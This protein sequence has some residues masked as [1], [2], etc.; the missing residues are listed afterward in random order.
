VWTTWR[1]ENS[2][3]M[4]IFKGRI[5]HNEWKNGFPPGSF[6]STSQAGWIKE[7]PFIK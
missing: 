4:A 5:F 3:T 6:V 7:Y 2:G 1:R